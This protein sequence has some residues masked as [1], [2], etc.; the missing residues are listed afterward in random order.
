V[1]TEWWAVSGEHPPT[2]TLLPAS[3]PYNTPQTQTHPHH[4]P[5]QG[6]DI[7]PSINQVNTDIR[8]FRGFPPTRQ[9]AANAL[10]DLLFASGNE[11]AGVLGG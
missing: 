10:D 11:T 4:P 3:S 5:P 8:G 1:S 6:V 9:P 2:H 7:L